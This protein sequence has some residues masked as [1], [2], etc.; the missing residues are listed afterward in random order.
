MIDVSSL[1]DLTKQIEVRI[2]SLLGTSENPM[3]QKDI[4]DSLKANGK[5]CREAL[6]SLGKKG[7]VTEFV[8]FG[9]TLYEA[10]AKV[11]SVPCEVQSVPCG[12]Q[13]VPC[14]VQSV[15][16]E[17]QSVPCEVQSVP[18]GVQSVLCEVQSVLTKVRNVL[19][20]PPEIVGVPS[21]SPVPPSFS[22]KVPTTNLTLVNLTRLVP[23]PYIAISALRMAQTSFVRN[24]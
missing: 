11:R 6:T 19:E 12:V 15:P 22:A 10:T 16:C 2:V 24:K 13:S 5:R 23:Q 20:S 3:R 8:K 18:C 21:V 1:T 14:G 4:I 7:F 9:V 17:V